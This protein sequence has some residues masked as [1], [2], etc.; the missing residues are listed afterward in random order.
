MRGRPS[1]RPDPIRTDGSNAFARFSM[2]VRVPKILTEVVERN[3]QYAASVKAA[4]TRLAEEIAGDGPFPALGFPSPD[5]SEWEPDCA[6][7]QGKRWLGSEWFFA[8]CY[9]YRCLM[10]AVRHFETGHDPFAAAKRQELQSASLWEGLDAL[11]AQSGDSRDS[12]EERFSGLLGAA[13]W[14]N[15]VD[16]SYAVGTAFGASGSGADL[17]ADDR[18]WAV[19]RLL[20]ARGAVELVADN[21]GSELT[22]DL[23]LV[24]AILSMSPARV[25]VH[26]KQHPMFVSDAIVA[27]VWA[28]LAAMRGRGRAP[29]QLATRLERAFAEERLVIAP[30]GFWNGPRF[31]WDLPARLERRFERADLLIL[32]GDAN[33][34]RAIGDAVWPSGAT[35]A[36]ATQ[37]LPA[38]LVCLRTMKSDALV[39]VGADRIAELDHADASWRINGRRGV[40]QGKP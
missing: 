37:Y 19:E 24:D 33:Y 26:V 15:R 5:A 9:V 22:M 36:D 29:E 32:K 10:I 7:R 1:P 39:G 23:V 28:L 40:I 8:E 4:V 13:L 3:P 14:G 31:L 17:L 25:T 12:R 21:T 6:A 16:L 11:L 20:G 18:S 34:R 35:F 30:D 27:D 38:P 2:A